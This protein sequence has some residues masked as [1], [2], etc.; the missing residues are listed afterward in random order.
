MLSS[1]HQPN[2]QSRAVA[3]YL[4]QTPLAHVEGKQAMKNTLLMPI[5][6]APV[7]RLIAFC[8]MVS[9]LVGCAS[10]PPPISLN[11]LNMKRAIVVE[12]HDDIVKLTLG[13]WS[14]GPSHNQIKA[15]E[16]LLSTALAG[17][18]RE[19]LNAYTN[20]LVH[21]LE[22]RGYTVRR[23][24]RNEL[25]ALRG[26]EGKGLDDT[27]VVLSL[28][29]VGFSYGTPTDKPLR[30]YVKMAL[31]YEF[32]DGRPIGARS[33]A[34]SARSLNLMAACIPPLENYSVPT[35]ESLQSSPSQH[36]AALRALATQAGHQVLKETFY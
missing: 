30:P 2:P 31:R 36:I 18:D 3:D 13:D 20:E 12:P 1:S 34:I 15:E 22:V 8:F 28:I 9:V 24:A 11:K 17:W 5:R 33:F 32:G 29:D 35:V 19:V 21:G 14:F 6:A 23:V 10:T 26:R 25:S 7:V 27:I 4:Q 16:R